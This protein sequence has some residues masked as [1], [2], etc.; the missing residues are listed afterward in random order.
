[1]R[2][3]TRQKG[4]QIGPS[5]SLVRCGV[6]CCRGENPN[7]WIPDSAH[8]PDFHF[9]FLQPGREPTFEFL[10]LEQTHG[11]GRQ[12][13]R[14]AWSRRGGKVG[15]SGDRGWNL[16]IFRSRKGIL[17]GNLPNNS[18]RKKNQNQMNLLRTCTLSLISLWKDSQ[19]QPSLSHHHQ[20]FI[21]LFNTKWW[22]FKING[23]QQFL[24]LTQRLAEISHDDKVQKTT[25]QNLS[26]KMT[27]HSS[28]LFLLDHL[29]S[30]MNFQKCCRIYVKNVRISHFFFESK[31]WTEG[32][33]ER[34]EEDFIFSYN[35]IWKMERLKFCF[36]IEQVCMIK[37]FAKEKKSRHG[38][39]LFWRN[40]FPI[41]W[42]IWEEYEMDTLCFLSLIVRAWSWSL[43][44]PYKFFSFYI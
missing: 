38:Q 19:H 15:R 37:E 24:L 10:P 31:K 40:G 12:G 4:F 11:S 7:P 36:Q 22:I 17:G 20:R 6:G 5:L 44:P 16:F 3:G 42:P 33:Q 28:I 14:E 32:N 34:I 9:T 35:G 18:S 29:E 13:E 27:I 8:L 43:T 23:I 41:E 21:P 25:I 26:L 2:T 30:Y 39:S 1:M